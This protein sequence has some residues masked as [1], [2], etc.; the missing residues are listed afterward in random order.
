MTKQSNQPI[1][2]IGLAGVGFVLRWVSLLRWN[3]AAATIREIRETGEGWC[4]SVLLVGHFVQG[5]KALKHLTLAALSAALLCGPVWAHSAGPSPGL[6]GPP[7]ESDCTICHTGTALNGG[8]GSLKVEIVGRTTYQ[9]GGKHTIRITLADPD[10]ARW[11]FQLSARLTGTVSK[12]GKFNLLNPAETI[13]EED[14][15]R[16]YVSHRAEGTRAG[17]R[18]SVTWD[19]EWEAPPAGAG[20][21]TFYAAGNAAN[22]NGN[23][24]GD[25]IY[26]TSATVAADG[27]GVETKSYTLPQ[28]AFG[29][30]VAGANTE[31]WTTELYFTNTG[32]STEAFTVD[33]YGN[34][35]APL[36]VPVAGGGTATSIPVTIS[37]GATSLIQLTSPAP[38]AQG[39]ASVRLPAT[40]KGV[41]IFRQS[42]NGRGGSEAMV[43]LSDDSKQNYVMIWDDAGF[44]TVMAVANPGDTPV[45]VNFTVRVAGG[46]QIGTGRVNLGP[47]EKKAFV[48]R[49][50]LGLP[51]MLGQR[52]A[53]NISVSL[54]K[55]SVLGLRFGEAAFTSNPPFEN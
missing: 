16:E 12:A 13:K 5:V 24:F 18:V 21:V 8:A 15:G 45:T 9:A 23:Q 52:G 48:I 10:A 33:F 49:D 39:W 53:M 11:G 37:Q 14:S 1:W 22:R 32:T 47:R 54:G 27:G 31:N 38:L 6:T 35:G 3:G 51:A 36:A 17:T 55:L 28:V 29:V 20:S 43:P 26:T 4:E 50:E 41:G 7:L 25:K 30:S 46:N 44:T 40:V 42:I 2:L 19:V 34:S